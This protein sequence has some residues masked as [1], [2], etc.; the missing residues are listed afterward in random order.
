ME[1]IIIDGHLP[2]NESRSAGTSFLMDDEVINLSEEDNWRDHDTS[3][4]YLSQ[5][6]A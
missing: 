6:A 1:I 4:P 3:P 2:Q 5:S